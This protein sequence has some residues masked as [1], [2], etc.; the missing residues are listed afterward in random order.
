MCATG[1]NATV[2]IMAVTQKYTHTDAC[3]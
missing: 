1:Q 3:S 2:L